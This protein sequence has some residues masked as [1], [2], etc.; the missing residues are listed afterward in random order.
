[1][2]SVTNLKSYEISHALCL[3]AAELLEVCNLSRKVKIRT[4][5]LIGQ[6][7]EGNFQF[8]LLEWKYVAHR[9]SSIG[10]LERRY[11][12]CRCL[13]LGHGVQPSVAEAQ[14]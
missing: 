1:M 8:T 10:M 12:V 13:I 2:Y 7:S 6:T 14:D 4:F 3:R 11:K 9:L 5:A